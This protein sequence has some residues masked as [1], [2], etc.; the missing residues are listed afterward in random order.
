MTTAK[1]TAKTK[2]RR[3]SAAGP[4]LAPSR[5]ARLTSLA[6]RAG[7]V[8]HTAATSAVTLI[9]RVPGTVRATR[10]GAQDT[11]SA[12]QTLPDSTLRWLAASSVGLGAGL[13]LAR[14]PRIVVAAG[15]VPALMAGAAIALRPV[16]TIGSDRS[17]TAPAG[18]APA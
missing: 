16:E 17:A 1:T 5:R 10:T 11:T 2:T 3:R 4:A 13:R 9:G 18:D 12:L 7:G 8:M 14:A 15:V 6:R